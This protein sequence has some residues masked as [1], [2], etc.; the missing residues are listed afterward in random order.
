MFGRNKKK[1]QFE[2]VELSERDLNSYIDYT[3]LDPRAT[4][5]D[6]EDLCNIAVKNKI[7]FILFSPFF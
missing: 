2:D 7:F 5:K 4:D 3:L 6:I 1:V